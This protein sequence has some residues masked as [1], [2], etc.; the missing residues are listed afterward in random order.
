MKLFFSLSP[1]M[2][3]CCFTIHCSI[4]TLPCAIVAL[5]PALSALNIQALSIMLPQE[6]TRVIRDTGTTKIASAS[7]SFPVVWS[8][9]ATPGFTRS[10]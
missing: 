9:G 7:R 2:C 5:S 6:G 1:V 10:S 3:T 4:A 8:S